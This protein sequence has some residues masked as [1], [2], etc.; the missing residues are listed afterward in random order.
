MAVELLPIECSTIM[1]I[2]VFF[3]KYEGANILSY[4]TAVPKSDSDAKIQ[5]FSSYLS[6]KHNVAPLS[7]FSNLKKQFSICSALYRRK[8]TI[9]NF[10]QFKLLSKINNKLYHFAPYSTFHTL[11]VRISKHP[12][13]PPT[14]PSVTKIELADHSTTI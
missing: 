3:V 6:S 4:P 2:L 12:N 8:V 7:T 5:G 10:L 11:N 13:I 1:Y 14:T 9:I